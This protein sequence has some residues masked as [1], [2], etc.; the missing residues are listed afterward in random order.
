MCE[1]CAG[2]EIPMTLETAVNDVG[3]CVQ[4]LAGIALSDTDSGVKTVLE[5]V[6]LLAMRKF[7]AEEL[8]PVR[9]MAAGVVELMEKVRDLYPQYINGRRD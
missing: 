1:Y 2:Q 7:T 3:G 4:I 8:A 5:T 9:M 6:E